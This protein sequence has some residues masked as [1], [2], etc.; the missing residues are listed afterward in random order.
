MPAARQPAMIRVIFAGT[1]EFARESLRALVVAD[2]RPVA[3]LTQPDRPAGRGKK[4][5]ASAVKTYAVEQGLPVLQPASLKSAA[6]IEELKAFDADLIIVAAYGLLLPQAA[7]EIPRV[8][9]V[10][11][12][13][14]RLPR[15]RGAAPVQAAILAGDEQTGVSLMQMELGLDSGPV[16]ATSSLAIAAQESAGE[17]H[18]RLARRGGE[19]LAQHLA[20]IAAGELQAE[21]QDE[22]Q[23][24]YAAKIRTQDAR[25]DWRRSAVE[26]ERVVRAYNPVPGAWT[27]VCGER[28]KCW[29]AMAIDGDSALPGTVM[30]ASAEGIDVA[31]GGGCLRITELQRPGRNRVSAG[32]FANQLDLTRSVLGDALG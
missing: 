3:V 27:V 20:A 4:L 18:D 31:C 17:L 19:L 1:P 15:W 30:S 9:C 13:A 28:V 2:V 21:I 12:H 24:S 22:A 16:Y 14:S 6:V 23:A 26:L 32:E 5:S 7:L 25:L 29:C 8:A 11:V 10:N